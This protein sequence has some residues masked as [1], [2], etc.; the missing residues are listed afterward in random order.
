MKIKEGEVKDVAKAM[1]L[2]SENGREGA[3]ALLDTKGGAMLIYNGGTISQGGVG[4]KAFKA[5]ARKAAAERFRH[6]TLQIRQDALD[7]AMKAYKEAL[8][9]PLDVVIVE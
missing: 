2:Y 6:A 4:P 8:E 7:T 1:R 5:W 9:E 3:T